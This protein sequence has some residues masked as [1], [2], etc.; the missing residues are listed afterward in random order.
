MIFKKL[1]DNVN[2]ELGDIKIHVFTGEVKFISQDKK[3]KEGTIFGKL[4]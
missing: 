2:R 1:K 3:L 4:S